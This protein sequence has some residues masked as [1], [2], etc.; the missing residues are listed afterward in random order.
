MIVNKKGKKQNST[1]LIDAQQNYSPPSE[2]CQIQSLHPDQP[3]FQAIPLFIY[4]GWCSMLRNVPSGQFRSPVLAMVPPSFFYVPVQ[5]QSMRHK[6][7]SLNYKKHQL[8]EIKMLVCY[9]HDCH[10]ESKTQ[11]YISYREEI[12]CIPEKTKT[13]KFCFLHTASLRKKIA[14]REWLFW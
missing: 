4:W 12:N 3:C 8:A 1:K 6:K 5:W 7:E 13:N 10:T 2:Q 11:H 9:Q 14:A